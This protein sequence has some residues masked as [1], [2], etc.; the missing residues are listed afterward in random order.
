MDQ[1]YIYFFHFSILIPTVLSFA[2]E[3]SSRDVSVKGVPDQSHKASPDSKVPSCRSF[4]NTWG[5]TR[6]LTADEHWTNMRTQACTT[7][8]RATMTRCFTR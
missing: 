1:H 5:T 3:P 6:R 7:H 4:G 8:G 2:A